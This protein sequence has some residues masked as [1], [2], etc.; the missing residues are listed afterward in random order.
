L[1]AVPFQLGDLIAN[2]F[3][4]SFVVGQKPLSTPGQPQTPD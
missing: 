2:D 1:T 4:G 3:A